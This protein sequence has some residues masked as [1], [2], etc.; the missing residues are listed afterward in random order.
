M[1]IRNR[2][3][4]TILLSAVAARGAA[5]QKYE[6]TWDSLDRRPVPGWFADAKFGIFIHWGPYSV[7]AWAPVG[8]YSE[9]YQYWMQNKTCFGNSHP[10]PTA[11]FDYHVKTY[12]KDFSYYRFGELFKTHDFDPAAWARLF[13][14]SGAKY[15]VLTSKHHDGFC[16]WPNEQANR[17][18]GR[19]W[20]SMDAGPRRDLV[21]ELKQAVEKT[22]VKFALYYS[23]Y[24]W[25]NPLWQDKTQRERFVDE[26]FL[27]QVKELVTRYRPAILWADGDWEAPSAFWKTPELLAWLYNESPVRDTA[28]VNDRWGKECRLKHGGYPTT[29]YDSGSN[30]DKPWEECRGIGFSFGY[31]RN[32]DVQDYNTAQTLILVLADTVSHGGNLLLDIGPDGSGKI[33]P[34]M[35]ERLLEIGRW[36]AVNGEAI[37]GTRKWKTPTQWSSGERLD[38]TQYKKRKNLSYVAGDFVLKQTLYPDPGMAVKEVFFTSKGRDVYAILP[39]LPEGRVLLKTVVP[40]P[41]TKVSLLGT[42]KTFSWRKTG[43]GIEVIVPPLLAREVPCQHA[44]VLKL[45]DVQ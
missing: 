25:F 7:P 23:L 33:P 20:N 22:P 35:Q 5:A 9:W 2:F 21:G 39:R 43:E 3:L 44:W 17:A 30:F 31:N 15:I 19:P 37:Y 18:Y 14:R 13:E 26:H 12:G 29:E 36:L 1:S 4:F 32:E 27:P 41:S 6:P 40:A 34:I 10:K 28:L 8:T 11:V 45:A 42:G 24:E 16:L 38:G